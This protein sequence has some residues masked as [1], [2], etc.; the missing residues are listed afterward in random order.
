M[1]SKC[2]TFLF[3][4]LMSVSVA[5]ADDGGAGLSAKTF[6]FK[7]KDA[8]RAATLIKPLRSG[9]GTLSI[10]PSSNTMVVTD[11]SDN[12]KNIAA[13]LAKFDAPAQSFK[14]EIRLVAASRSASGGKVPEGLKDLA[15][16][17]SVL[18]FNSFE[19]L[20]EI[21]AE[22]KEGDPVM[23]DQFAPGYRAD[24]R[25]GE[26]DPGSDSIRV[27]D[28]RLQRV[29]GDPKNAELT[30][31]LKTSLNLKIGQQVILGASKDPQ[32][33]RALM[34]VLVSKRP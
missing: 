10:Q 14:I 8:E 27:G 17:L 33:D 31:L 24:F 13:T 9:E 11:H 29:Q 21:T 16:K 26:F 1:K 7:F 2:I 22:A 3:A 32:S 20:G 18:K 5:F 4:L 28:F 6:Q 34:L 12:L 15:A 19:K 30:Q 25:L 23:V